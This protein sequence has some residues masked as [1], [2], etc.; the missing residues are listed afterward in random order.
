MIKEN[1]ASKYLLYAIGEIFLVVIGILIALQINNW[2]EDS[3]QSRI[4]Q[5]Y[6]VAL[7]EEFKYSHQKLEQVIAVNKSNADYALKISDLMGPDIPAITEKEFSTLA[8]EMTNW[9]VIYHPNQAVLDEIISSGKLSIF[10]NAKLKFALSSSKGLLSKIR[11][12]EDEH[13]VVRRD[14]IAIMNADGNA[15]K[16]ITDAQGDTFDIKESKFKL[17]NLHLLQSQKL[18]NELTDFIL[19]AR[20]LNQ[21][22]YEELKTELDAMLKLIDNEIDSK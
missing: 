6:L 11:F 5:Q 20:Y 17:G 12:Q 3:K 7:K 13:A 21:N 10:S 4:E 2:N 1:K 15:K 14:I 9:E 19:T 22:Y 18:E 16:M 8:M